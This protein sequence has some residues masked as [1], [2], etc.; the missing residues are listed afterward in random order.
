M[1]PATLFIIGI[2]MPPPR[3]VTEGMPGEISKSR[4]VLM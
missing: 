2:I 3:A 1:A 4:M